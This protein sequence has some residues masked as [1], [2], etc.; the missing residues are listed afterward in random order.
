MPARLLA[1]PSI[2]KVDFSAK[3]RKRKVLRQAHFSNG[4]ASICSV[5]VPAFPAGSRGKRVTATAFRGCPHRQR[6]HVE[7]TDP[8][9]PGAV[10]SSTAGCR[11]VDRACCRYTCV[12]GNLF[13]V[14]TSCSDF[15]D[16]YGC[17][18]PANLVACC[19]SRYSIMPF[20]DVPF[21][22]YP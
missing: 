19:Q 13:S 8:R 10:L 12:L 6:F 1:A 7:T 22:V 20:V 14:V 4:C 9:G 5:P 17:C 18:R 16:W 11:V 21:F 2:Q 15:R 3:I